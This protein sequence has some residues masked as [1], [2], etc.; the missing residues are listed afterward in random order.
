[1]LAAMDVMGETV[2][3]TRM[4][5]EAPE[6]SAPDGLDEQPARVAS[7]SEAAV[8]SQTVRFMSQD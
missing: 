2:V 5:P 4:A 6:A 1:M 7:P 3:A 8:T